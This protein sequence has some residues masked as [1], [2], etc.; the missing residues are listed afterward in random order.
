MKEGIYETRRGFEV[1][2]SGRLMKSFQRKDLARLYLYSSAK[3]ELEDLHRQGLVGK[4][5]KRFY[6]GGRKPV[7]CVETGERFSSVDEAADQIG[8]TNKS[9]Y[10]AISAK[11]VLAGFHWKYEEAIK[12][13]SM[14]E[15]KRELTN[16]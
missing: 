13:R 8:C 16:N 12:N 1:W 11:R 15:R 5:P 2:Y 9:L 3:D 6:G 14:P 7:V 4:A 10:S